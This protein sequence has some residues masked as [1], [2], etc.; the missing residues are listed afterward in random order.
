MGFI[1]K[2][3]ILVQGLNGEFKTINDTPINRILVAGDYSYDAKSDQVIFEYNGY[4]GSIGSKICLLYRPG[5][6]RTGTDCV[7]N[8]RGRQLRIPKEFTSINLSRLYILCREISLHRLTL[9]AVDNYVLN[10]KDN[11]GLDEALIESNEG[12]DVNNYELVT[13]SENN[14]HS[15][16]WH[17]AKDIFKLKLKF[18][19]RDKVI[20]NLIDMS[21][22]RK[23]FLLHLRIQDIDFKK[24]GII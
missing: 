15:E 8:C 16:A 20:M 18:S 1:T 12:L 11:K 4:S 23:Q 22:D 9:D 7:P 21:G 13:Q 6:N 24:Y 19:A 10:H 5:S 17:R 2:N 14:A 3:R